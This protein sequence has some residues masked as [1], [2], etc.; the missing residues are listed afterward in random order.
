LPN[1]SQHNYFLNADSGGPIQ[2][3]LVAVKACDT[4]NAIAPYLPR[5][6]TTVTIIRLQNGM[7]TLA[8]IA[9]PSHCNII[10]AVT[11]D[12]AWRDGNN[13]HVVAENST[14]FGNGMPVIDP[15]IAPLQ[16]HWHGFQ[17]DKDIDCRQWQKLAINAVI[18]PLT[19]IYQCQNGDLIKHEETHKLMKQ[20]A[21]EIDQ[22]LPLWMPDWPGNSYQ[23]AKQI[24]QQTAN[25]TSSMLADIRARRST[26]IDF[27]NG[28]LVASAKKYGLNLPTHEKVIE[29]VRLAHPNL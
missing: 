2:C 18:N 7:G 10:H 6:A 21:K 14:W 1:G 27:I 3:L 13:V 5:L 28:H 19:A 20:L 4:R 23:Q 11:T 16:N 25:N 26:E 24:A 12:G 9:L 8:D 15:Q 22:A 17:W 29:Q